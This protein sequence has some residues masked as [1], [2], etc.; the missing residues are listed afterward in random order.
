MDSNPYNNLHESLKWLLWKIDATGT[1]LTVIPGL[2]PQNWSINEVKKILIQN[3]VI[4]FDLAKIEM[5]IRNPTG[6]QEL[7]GPPLELFE[8]GKRRF[9]KLQVTPMQVLFA[10]DAGVLQTDYQITVADVL[11][12]LAE[13]AVVYGIDY[14]TID[15]VV[16]NQIYGREFTVAN[17]V[18]PVA[19]Q[20]AVITEVVT[21]DPDIKPFLNEDG[22]ADFKKWD[23]IRQIKQDEIICRRIP[24]TPGIPGI[25]VFGYPLSPTPGEDFALPQGVNT[26]AIDNET[27]LVAA[28]NGFLYRDQRYICVGCVY[29]IDGDVDFK[30]GNIEYFGDILVKG[31]VI[32]GFSIVADGNISIHGSVE[33]SYIESKKGSITLKGSVFGQ[34]KA[35]IIADKNINAENIQDSNLKAGE[36]V[37]VRGQIRNC[38]IETKHLEQ[39]SDGQIISS[40]VLF[41][42]YLKCGCIGGKVESLNEFTLLDIDRRQHKKELMSANELLQKLLGAIEILQNKLLELKPSDTSPETINQKKILTSKLDTC[43]NSKEQLLIKR[44]RLT[45]LIE[46]MPDKEALVTA[47]TLMP[48]LKLSMYGSIR[49]FKHELTHL[50]IGWRSGSVKMEGI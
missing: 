43:N 1:Y 12:L 50:Q 2:I 45:K 35:T 40:T 47:Y 36:V 16:S 8:N 4:N 42:G 30:T 18:P 17:A 33:A 31:N 20:D 15:E 27:K 48:V 22:T 25:S 21:I 28:R 32:S 14:E 19:G 29:V 23:N 41:S 5:A 10:M 38:K 11:F 3:H 44:K 49:E 13:K 37:K 34:N 46:M 6:E 39:P 9:L 7:V 24:P 26:K